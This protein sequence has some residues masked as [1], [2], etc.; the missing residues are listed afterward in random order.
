MSEHHHPKLHPKP[1]ACHFKPTEPCRFI[2]SLPTTS[3]MSVLGWIAIVMLLFAIMIKISEFKKANDADQLYTYGTISG[4]LTDLQ[5]QI[6]NTWVHVDVTQSNGESLDVT[7]TN[8]WREAQEKEK[9]WREQAMYWVNQFI[10][11][12]SKSSVPTVVTQY[13]NLPRYLETTQIVYIYVPTKPKLYPVNL[14]H[15]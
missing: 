10:D 6:S 8:N 11:L 5:T 15:P 14:K 2:P 3:L 13:V 9:Y 12:K 4:Q 1:E 7:L